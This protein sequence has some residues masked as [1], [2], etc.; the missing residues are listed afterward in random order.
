MPDHLHQ[1]N[2][3]YSDKEDR[4]L[5]RTSTRRGHEY[6]IW[7]TRRFTQLLLQALGNEIR[8]HGSLFAPAVQETTTQQVQ[9]EALAKPYEEEKVNHLPLGEQGILAHGIQ[10]HKQMDGSLFLQI[11]SES[12][13]NLGLNLKWDLLHMFHNLV[14]QGSECAGW[15]IGTISEEHST[16]IH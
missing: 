4:L 10:L 13:F 15:D 3:S 14:V 5:L 8:D 12:G 6:R 7:L 16:R 2:I 9:E 11:H 1:M